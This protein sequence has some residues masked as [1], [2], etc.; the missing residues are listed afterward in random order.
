MPLLRKK[1]PV[2]PFTNEEKISYLYIVSTLTQNPQLHEWV[3]IESLEGQIANEFNKYLLKFF[4]ELENDS[5]SVLETE[6]SYFDSAEWL[7]FK[8][9]LYI[10]PDFIRELLN[11]NWGFKRE[12][13]Q[14]EQKE[15]MRY[16][17][18]ESKKI[19]TITSLIHSITPYKDGKPFIFITFK[20]KKTGG[21]SISF[22]TKIR[23]KIFIESSVAFENEPFELKL[24]IQYLFM[25]P[26]EI[27]TQVTLNPEFRSQVDMQLQEKFRIKES[28]GS[29]IIIPASYF[30]GEGV[31]RILSDILLE[32]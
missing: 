2:A 30:E 19:N 9:A 22:Q 17:V 6:K 26:K 25:K 7:S 8:K 12:I 21:K 20:E 29:Y 1:L 16:F 14:K 15:L 4:T 32:K 5:K 23:D 24:A 3:G 13:I 28:N 31:S 11:Y 10:V 18:Q 27:Y